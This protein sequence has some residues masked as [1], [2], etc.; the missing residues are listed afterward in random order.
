MFSLPRHVYFLFLS[1]ALV[2][3][4]MPMNVLVGG[5]VGQTLAPASW[6][7][8]LPITSIVV[9]TTLAT[10]PVAAIM[11]RFGRREGFCIGIAVALV[12]Q[13]AAIAALRSGSFWLFC[14][15]T[16]LMGFAIAAMQQMRFAAAEYVGHEQAPVAIAVVMLH[17]VVAAIIGPELGALAANGGAGEAAGPGRFVPAYL[18]LSIALAIALVWTFLMLPRGALRTADET[19]V[20]DA[21]SASQPV[22]WVAAITSV[23]AFAVMSYIMTATPVSMHHEFHFD[24]ADAK[25]VV[26]WHIVAMFLP[27]LVTG[28]LVQRFSVFKCILF[29][30]LF[31]VLSCLVAFSGYS[32]MHFLVSLVLLGVGWNILF[33]TGT[34]M[35]A[36]DNASHSQQARHDFLLFAAQ[37]TAT[38]I[39]GGTLLRFGWEGVIVVS[40]IA[41]LPCLVAAGWF[42][43][44]SRAYS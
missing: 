2:G 9:G 24:L 4:I 13:F 6:L 33:T 20:G 19:K 11:K 12:A 40:L 14:F 3:S 7:A 30:W 21:E 26:Q 32:H 15:C 22:F 42:W 10:F 8:T 44:R 35:L 5:I 16:M 27:S 36:Q 31:F 18:G 23:T 43:R 39:A 29:G 25:T 41:L 34:N 37:A 28:R 38:A 17:G 1:C